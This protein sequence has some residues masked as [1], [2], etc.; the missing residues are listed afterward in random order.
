MLW[1]SWNLL[2]A[3]KSFMVHL[4]RRMKSDFFAS[5][6][7][8]TRLIGLHLCI[9]IAQNIRKI[10]QAKAH[11]T[12]EIIVFLAKFQHLLKVSSLH[13]YEWVG[14]GAPSVLYRRRR[15]HAVQLWPAAAGG[16]SEMAAAIGGVSEQKIQDFQPSLRWLSHVRQWPD[17]FTVIFPD[18]PLF[19]LLTLNL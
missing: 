2:T 14:G 10:W 12:C 13:Q 9:T 15:R 5:K 6:I 16:A 18:I 11:R 8:S 17:Y 4:W 7:V 19:L 3:F 1:R